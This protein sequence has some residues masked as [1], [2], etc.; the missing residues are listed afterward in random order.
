MYLHHEVYLFILEQTDILREGESLL[1][2][3]HLW[4]GESLLGQLFVEPVIDELLGL[5][6]GGSVGIEED[7]WQFGCLVGHDGDT[8]AHLA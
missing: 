4:L 3:G 6:E 7:H 2:L 5:L 8:C 1:E